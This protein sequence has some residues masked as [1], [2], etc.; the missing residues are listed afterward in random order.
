MNLTD[1][2]FCFFLHHNP[3]RDR[4]FLRFSFEGIAYKFQVLL[5]GLSLTS[6]ICK[7]CAEATLSPLCH[8]GMRVFAYLDDLLL[9][10]DSRE[11]AVFPFTTA[12]AYGWGG[13]I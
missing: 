13:R 11:Q 6:L 4:K 12:G 5:F 3:L 10:A 2:F 1:L 7:I 9:A 8:Q